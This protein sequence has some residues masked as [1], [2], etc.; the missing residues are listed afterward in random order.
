MVS[1]PAIEEA[2]QARFPG[3]QDGPSIAVIS[4]P[5]DDQPEL[6]L[7]TT[8][9]ID[10]AEANEAIRAAGLS[11]LYNIRA[12]RHVDALPM[13]GTGKTDYRALADMLKSGIV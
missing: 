9:E 1:L 5:D 7:F 6:V 3:H 12:V 2:L 10:R 11:G 8:V 4:T 13:L